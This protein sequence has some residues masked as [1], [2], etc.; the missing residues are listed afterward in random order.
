[1]KEIITYEANDGT[2]FNDE[3]E[4]LYYEKT[5]EWE[6]Y[7]SKIKFFDYKKNLLET[8]F[9][10]FNSGSVFFISVF[11]DESAE[12]LATQELDCSSPFDKWNKLTTVAGM[13][14]YD[15]NRDKW[16]NLDEEIEWYTSLKDKLYF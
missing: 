4:C 10:E 12:F 16:V 11:D 15:E 7:K 13:Y 14:W 8:S 2:L 6:K 5:K 3:D 1:M 9:K